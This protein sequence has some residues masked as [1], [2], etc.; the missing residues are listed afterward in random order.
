VI[1]VTAAISNQKVEVKSAT[2]SIGKISP[3][4]KILNFSGSGE[5]ID[6]I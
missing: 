2:F 5:K 3:A 1:D 4:G 6:L